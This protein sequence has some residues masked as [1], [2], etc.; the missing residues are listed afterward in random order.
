MDD[1]KKLC[2]ALA[3]VLELAEGNTIS[4]SDADLDPELKQEHG[5]QIKAIALVDAHLIALRTKK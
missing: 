1:N 2:A 3:L 5:K 4:L